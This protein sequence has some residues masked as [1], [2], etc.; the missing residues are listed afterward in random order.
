M[1]VKPRAIALFSG[2]LD[3]ALAVRLL[4]QQGFEVEGLHVRTLFACCQT[5][6]ARLAHQLGIPLHVVAVGEDYLGLIRRPRYGYG[7]GM[8]PCVDC[9][10]YMARLARRLMQQ[11]QAE[12]VIS[13]EVLGQR[14]MSQK[15][16]DLEII[17][18]ESGL[19][20]RLLRP[21]SA[22]RLP[23]T[24]AE[25]V[26]LVDRQQLGDLAGRSRKPQLALA[27][28]FGLENVPAP[29]SGCAL[30][31]VRFAR[32]VRDLLEH[33]PCP[34]GADYRLLRIGRHVR[35]DAQTK[36]VLGRNAAQNRV[37]EGLAL[38]AE[39][40]RPGLLVPAD[41]PGPSALILGPV[42]K[43][44][45]ERTGALVLQLARRNQPGTLRLVT[46]EHPAGR[47]FRAEPCPAG[48]PA[49]P[50]SSGDPL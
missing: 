2:G 13:G 28:R 22:R 7:R 34:C 33:H 15:R 6:A 35:L 18:R 19:G 42:T 37:L 46:A 44:I 14:N 43:Q 48:T 1:M 3:S 20:G 25:E 27:R 5:P 24:V 40:G 47:A 12:L 9:R 4:Q 45:V 41:F 49:G 16:V 21:L 39:L 32:R 23:P 17:A 50:K 10:I 8:N 26:G 29:S 11:R 31:D 30:A 36:V 38:S